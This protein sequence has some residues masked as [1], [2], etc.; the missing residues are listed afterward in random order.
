MATAAV[1]FQICQSDKTFVFQSLCKRNL[2][3]YANNPKCA[4]NAHIYKLHNIVLKPKGADVYH[5]Y[6]SLG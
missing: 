4:L 5:I 2:P 1:S 6:V 3:R